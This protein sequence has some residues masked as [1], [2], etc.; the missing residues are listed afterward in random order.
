[1]KKAILFIG[2][3]LSI[4]LIGCSSTDSNIIDSDVSAPSSISGKTVEFTISSGSGGFPSSGTWTTVL[5]NTENQYVATFDTANPTNT[6]GLF[7]YRASGNKGTVS[8]FD[9]ATGRGHLY[10]TF[11]STTSGTYT[12]DAEHSSSA[13]QSGT[14]VEQ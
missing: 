1:M 2:M 11:T 7:T 12:A 8:F 14:F 13:K 3:F 6:A 4:A 5:S 9:S 10:L